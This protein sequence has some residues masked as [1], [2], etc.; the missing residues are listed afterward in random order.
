MEQTPTEPAGQAPVK[1]P[2]AEQPK[3]NS[4]NTVVIIVA[5]VVVF[6]IVALA[7]G[8]FVM[9]SLK[10]KVSQ[11]IGQKIGES[12]VEKAIEK[13][14]GQKADVNA[15]GDSVSIKTDAGTFAASETGN[16]PLPSD[17][18]SDIFVMSGAKITFATS[19]PG[20]AASGT[21]ASYMV[22]YATSQSAGDVA[23][24]Y[25]EEMVKNGWRKESEA[26]YGTLMLDF[27]K[28]KRDA[29]VMIMENQDGKN[30]ATTVSITGSEN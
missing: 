19:T 17:F 26:N 9:R 28:D 8:Y 10:A 29:L 15:D 24:R 3:K 27:K 13:S 16:I 12:M 21:K 23:S 20:D 7:G 14:T 25:K 2:T 5:V 22:S 18:P 30:G 1:P 4:N 6:G 11:S